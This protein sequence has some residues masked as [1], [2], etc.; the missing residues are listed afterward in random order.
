[1]ELAQRLATYAKSL[2]FENL[3]EKVVHEAKRRVLDALGCAIGAFDAEPVKI[4]REISK[5]V[6]GKKQATIL[7]TRYKT[8]PELATF[9]NGTMIRYLDFMDTYFFN[10]EIV[11]PEDN[12]AA[13]FSVAESEKLSG[14]DIILS[15]VLAYETCCRF[16]DFA[17]IRKR[18]WDHVI[19]I[20]ISSALVASKIIGLSTDKMSQALSLA[21]T[22]NIPLRQIRVGRLSMWKG[23]AVAY[24]S[25][26]GVF[27][28]NLARHGIT[29]P[30]EIFE[31]KHGFFNQITGKSSLSID[32]FCSDGKNF[33]ILQA[34]MKK[35][36]VEINAQSAVEAA[37]ELRSKIKIH[38][39]KQINVYTS[40]PSYE[41]IADKEKWNPTNRE[42]ADHSLPYIVC[43]ALVDGEITEK[44]FSLKR[45]SDPKLRELMQK[46]TVQSS[47]ECD[48][49]YYPGI[50]NRVE[51]LMNSG[52]KF[53]SNI[54]YP[55]GSYK[56][57]MN[58]DEVE[59][60]FRNLTKKFLTKSQRDRIVTAVW[61]L[62]K[63]KDL[64]R[65][66]SL[67]KVK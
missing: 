8:T 48:K 14:K 38:E 65:L 53:S 4:V 67:V 21:I 18:G 17:N 60:K 13:I 35:Y 47:E 36:P 54:I 32:K 62:E 39:I 44:Q 29:G 57:P 50:P 37:F 16:V 23:L 6:K 25:M 61:N 52:E 59:D 45:I 9:V 11:H 64:S 49:N 41:I 20:T 2:S 66:F 40:T 42:T 58:D 10:G 5:N 12:L 15:T 27:A 30:N 24:A 46:T 56:N 43:V 1:M 22:S 34:H 19:W 51:V 31:G 7:G 3:A 55:R 33:K 28:T 26:A 63:I